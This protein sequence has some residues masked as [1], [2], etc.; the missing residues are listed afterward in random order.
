MIHERTICPT[1]RHFACC[2]MIPMPSSE[3]TLTCVVLTGSALQLALLT[4][5]AVAIFA[6][7]PSPGFMPVI[8]FVSSLPVFY[9]GWGGR[10]AI[11]IA[12]LGSMGTVTRVEA[13]ALSVALG[14]VVFLASLPGAAFWAMRPSM[15]KAIH[16]EIQRA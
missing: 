2:V 14:V 8:F 4:S 6:A 5:A 11:V 1:L 10:E 7:K 9:L 15:R 3:P 16:T 12:T 13:V